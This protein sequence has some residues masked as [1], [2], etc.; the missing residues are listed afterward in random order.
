MELVYGERASVGAMGW[1]LH[2]KEEVSLRPDL[3]CGTFPR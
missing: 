3:N 2:D 1:V